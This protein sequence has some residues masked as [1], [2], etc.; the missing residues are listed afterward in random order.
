M[1]WPISYTVLVTYV[2]SDCVQHRAGVG[3][4]EPSGKYEDFHRVL[5]AHGRE[6]TAVD[7]MVTQVD[8]T[9]QLRSSTWVVYTGAW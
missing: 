8:A 2:Y 1:I 3:G 4:G 9:L 6:A 7:Q 5:E